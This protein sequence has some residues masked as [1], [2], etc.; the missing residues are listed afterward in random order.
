MT[1]YQYCD[2]RVFSLLFLS[3][4]FGKT[5]TSHVEK[6]KAACSSPE[7]VRP[8]HCDN[9]TWHNQSNKVQ[10]DDLMFIFFV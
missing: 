8:S 4:G 7:A 9:Y 2:E 1:V 10:E 3:G 5:M 6:P